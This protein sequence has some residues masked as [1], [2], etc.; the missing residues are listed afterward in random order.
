M[1]VR[2]GE[3]G[4]ER[5]RERGREGEERERE[6]AV[7]GWKNRCEYNMTK[8]CDRSREKDGREGQ[9]GRE[10]ESERECGIG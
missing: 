10:G 7:R 4:R 8:T 2:G 3:G 6:R 9:K 1:E 5:G